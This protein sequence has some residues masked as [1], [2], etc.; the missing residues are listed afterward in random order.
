MHHPEQGEKDP[1]DGYQMIEP[2]VLQNTRRAVQEQGVDSLCV[3]DLTDADLSHIPW[4][5]SALH[6]KH[7]AQELLRAQAGEIDYL[8]VRSPEGYPVSIGGVDYTKESDGGYLW[9]LGTHPQ[10]RGLGIGTRLIREAERRIVERGKEWARL[11]VE[12]DNPRA[13]ELY[14]RLGYEVYGTTTDSWK[15]LDEDGHEVVHTADLFQMRKRVSA[16]E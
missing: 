4:S 6:I 11:E 15:Q 16:V 10:L 7:V 8:A 1:L 13:K 14:E 9:Q 12:L 3:D 2:S 5:G